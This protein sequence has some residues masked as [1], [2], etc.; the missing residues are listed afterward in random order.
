MY[1]EALAELRQTKGVIVETRVVVA[2]TYAVSGQ[3]RPATR[4]LAELLELAKRQYVHRYHIAIIYAGLGDKNQALAW[5]E[6]AYEERDQWLIW[7]KVEPM[8]DSLRSD[9]RFQDLLRRVG[10]PP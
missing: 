5:L 7:L 10:L 1:E 2:H 4:V 6:K 3:R 9:P 8:V